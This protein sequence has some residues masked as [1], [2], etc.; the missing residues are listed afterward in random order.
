MDTSRQ[1]AVDESSL[2]ERS[3]GRYEEATENRK[4]TEASIPPPS[5]RQHDTI[6]V[7]TYTQR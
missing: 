6:G 7:L 2:P 1:V 4:D 5:Q 3:Y